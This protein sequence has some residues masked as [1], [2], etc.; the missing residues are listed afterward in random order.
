MIETKTLYCHVCCV[1]HSFTVSIPDGQVKFSHIWQS[2]VGCCAVIPMS[3]EEL[4]YFTATKE[5]EN[6]RETK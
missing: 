6:A 3:D 2:N 5:E 1:H 4:E